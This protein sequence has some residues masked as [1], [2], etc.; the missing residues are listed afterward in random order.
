MVV[1]E[2]ERASVKAVLAHRHTE[3][4]ESRGS[5]ATT[6]HTEHERASPHD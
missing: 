6:A 1:V 4:A 5:A 3:S 2:E